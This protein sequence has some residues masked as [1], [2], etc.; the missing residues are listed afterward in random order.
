[1][2]IDESILSRL[3]DEQRKKVET[4][5]STEELLALAKEAGFELTQEQM[6]AV[7]GG[8]NPCDGLGCWAYSKC[9]ANQ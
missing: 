3:T 6:E 1:M 2:N 4:A 8:W 5:R 9:A 7:A